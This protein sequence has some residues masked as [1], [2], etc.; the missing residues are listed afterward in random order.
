MFMYKI[1]P[2]DVAEL[3]RIKRLIVDTAAKERPDLLKTEYGDNALVM[4]DGYDGVEWLLFRQFG[5]DMPPGAWHDAVNW[6]RA[7]FPVETCKGGELARKVHKVKS[8]VWQ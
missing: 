4:D 1:N 7:R 6:M 5:N 3:E 2:A 8:R